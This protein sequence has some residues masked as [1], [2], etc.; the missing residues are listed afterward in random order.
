MRRAGGRSCASPPS[1]ADVVI[2]HVCLD[3]M[4][5][6]S[7]RGAGLL[8]RAALAC[9][10]PSWAL[11]ASANFVEAVSVEEA[12]RADPACLGGATVSREVELFAFIEWQRVKVYDGDV[13]DEVRPCGLDGDLSGGMTGRG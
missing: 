8:L 2:G 7:A 1:C 3:V 11:L 9:Q 4:F 5:Y 10:L 12:L 13:D 6:E